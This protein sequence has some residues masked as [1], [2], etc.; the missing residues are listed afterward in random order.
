MGRRPGEIAELVVQFE[1]FLIVPK[2]LSRLS[3][4]PGQ[5]AKLVEH[6]PYCPC[7]SGLAPDFE[8][9]FIALVSLF[10]PAL[11]LVDTTDQVQI[12]PLMHGFA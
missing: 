7:V 1:A 9:A 4:Y 12:L 5:T 6:C 2:R 10:V 3:L 8:A 11:L